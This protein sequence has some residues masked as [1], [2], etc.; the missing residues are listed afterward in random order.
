MFNIVKQRIKNYI[1]II[2]KLINK[3]QVVGGQAQA[4]NNILAQNCIL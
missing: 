3:I 1:Y 4:G 2:M